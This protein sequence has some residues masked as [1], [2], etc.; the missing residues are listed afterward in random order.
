MSYCATR[1][2]IRQ[3]LFILLSIFLTGSLSAQEL[4]RYKTVDT[5]ELYLEVLR[6]PENL[7]GDA[8]LPAIVFFFGGGWKNGNR[9]HFLP[10]AKYLS[11]RGLVCFLADYRTASKHGTKPFACLEDAKSAIRYIRENA[12]GLGIDAHKLIAAGGSAGGHLA[13][14]AALI[15]GYNAEE[16]NLEISAQPNALV[17]FNPVIDNGPSGYGHE[18]IQEHYASFSPL[19]NIR[20]GAPPMLFLL[21]TKDDLIPVETAAYFRMSMERVGSP[22]KLVLYEGQKHGF[23]NHRN[24]E[25]YKQ[26]LQETDRFLTSLDYLSLQPIVKID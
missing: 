16:D 7:V 21:G 26:T 18:R 19:H 13:A 24:F 8:P 2:P 3:A 14:A 5:T 4:L 22:C 10:Q 20:E 6:P 17:L 23:F 1:R 11:Q 12:D 9:H 15:E 25:Y